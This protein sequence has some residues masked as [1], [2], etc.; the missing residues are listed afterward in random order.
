MRQFLTPFVV[1]VALSANAQQPN[2]TSWNYAR[3]GSF[4]LVTK[5]PHTFDQLTNAEGWTNCTIGLSDVFDASA[6][7]K[8]VGLPTNEYGT[9]VKPTEGERCA[10][11]FAWKDDMRKQWDSDY[12][13]PFM[14][15]WNSYS[16]YLMTELTAPLKEGATYSIS[17]D[18]MLAGN[19][20]R[21]TSS[22]GAYASP[23]PLHRENRRF[24]EEKAQVA[25]DKILDER[26]KWVHITGTFEADGGEQYL[27]VGVY[28]YVGWE[29][30]KMVE[31]Y[32]NQYAYYFVDNVTLKLAPPQQ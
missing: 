18:V 20:D 12:K 3:N 1:L 29:T 22:I 11:F 23:V 5:P 14:K 21:A 4:E 26:G 16:E 17:L 15:G 7:E 10:G 32:D 19:S 9:D 31:S 28:P 8:T 13:D 27:I 25:T 30:K 24:L 6:S 2:D